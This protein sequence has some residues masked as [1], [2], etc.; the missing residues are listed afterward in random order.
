MFGRTRSSSHVCLA[1]W[2][3]ALW[4]LQLRPAYAQDVPSSP[5]LAPPK[6]IPSAPPSYPEAA[7]AQSPPPC[8]QVRVRLSLNERGEVVDVEPVSSP[9][10]VLTHAAIEAAR[11][12]RFEPATRDGQ[13]VAARILYEFLFEPPAQP[14]GASTP[15]SAAPSAPGKAAQESSPA[16]ATAQGQASAL[17]GASATAQGA[18]TQPSA[19]GATAQGPA[20]PLRE[21]RGLIES[22]AYGGRGSLEFRAVDVVVT[23]SRA[24]E[25]L[26]QA[27]V[28]TDVIGRKIIRETGARDAGEA[29][30]HMPSL[31]LTRTF[32]GTEIWLRGL[33]PEYTLVLLDGDRLIGRSG[34][35][36]DLT[37]IGVERIDRIEIVRG[38][39]SALYG[40]DALAGVVNIIGQPSSG[41][42]RGRG[43]LSGGYMPSADNG[44]FDAS[45]WATQPIV[46]GLEVQA[47]AG[48]HA[49][50]SVV[51]E[52]GSDVTALSSRRQWSLLTAAR[53]QPNQTHDVKISGEY[54]RQRMQGVDEGAAG[55]LYDR[56]QL[57][58]QGSVALSYRMRPSER[59]DWHTRYRGSFFREQ[60]ARD[61][62]GSAAMDS[63]EDNRERLH[64]LT[65]MLSWQPE[66][67]HST[68]VGVEQQLQHLRAPR[69]TRN[70]ERSVTSVFAQHRW[71]PW[72][73]EHAERVECDQQLS[74]VPGARLDVDSQFGQQVSPKLALRYDPLPCLTLRAAYGR[75]F[76]APSFQQL[77]LRFENPTVGYIVSGNPSLDAERSHGF[78][79]SAS[80]TPAP[81]M[82]A[83]VAL[84]RN[85]LRNMIASITQG[86]NAAETLF[87]YANVARAWT[88]G[89][90]LN[91][92]LEPAPWLSVDLSYTFTQAWN[93]QLDRPLEGIARHR[94]TA[95]LRF[96]HEPWGLRARARGSLL[97]GR[98]YFGESEEDGN[99]VLGEDPASELRID[100]PV[101][102]TADMRVEK[103]LGQHLEVFAGIDNLFDA[104]DRYTVL[105]PRTF[106]AGL[107]GHY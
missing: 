35:A 3:G 54:D 31:Q 84:F 70:G 45:A 9:A 42:A 34:G 26:N 24:P 17:P 32:R 78:D 11:T 15:A 1:L 102:A 104:A 56:T 33:D 63:V 44:M 101:L 25:E 93:V 94:P 40:S 58:E 60:Y 106:Y 49:A 19:S 18:V 27:V 98:V 20:A 51:D 43:F 6:P 87:T 62:R 85:D 67:A 5:E 16:G 81:G 55:A 107:S 73:R 7:L 71:K 22:A 28:F 88:M 12:L 59:L 82:S 64:Q 83:F 66:A 77:F 75:G 36:I 72:T 97:I 21:E 80:Y 38:P 100:T 103:A 89:V 23:G 79:L 30:E 96:Q 48:L 13:P 41:R 47:S 29:L 37:R 61:Q 76:R 10:D 74:V 14:P 92:H 57:R 4:I 65:S 105:R 53:Y 8:G 46:K 95:M 50:P 39:A 52:E 86:A 69:L 91:T 2:L 99:T 68:T 90:E